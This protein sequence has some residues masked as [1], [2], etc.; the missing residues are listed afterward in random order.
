[1]KVSLGCFIRS[2]DDDSELLSG[3]I[4]VSANCT[5]IE[6]LPY[7]ASVIE[8]LRNFLRSNRDTLHEHNALYVSVSDVDD[9]RVREDWSHYTWN[10]SMDRDGEWFDNRD[11]CQ[12]PNDDRKSPFS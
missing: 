8:G 2:N 3:E 5:S 9:D 7:D 12:G 11:N 1:M 10:W 6:E 4:D